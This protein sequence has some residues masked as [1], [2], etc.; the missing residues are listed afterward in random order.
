MLT[1]FRRLCRVLSQ[2]KIFVVLNIVLS[3]KSQYQMFLSVIKR[4]E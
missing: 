4:W 3:F 1:V 2:S